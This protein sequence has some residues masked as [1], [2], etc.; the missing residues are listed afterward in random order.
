MSSCSSDDWGA[1][2]APSTP[3]GPPIG[4][5]GPEAAPTGSGELGAV[6][7]G[8]DNSDESDDWGDV[9]AASEPVAAPEEHAPTL[10]D[11][12]DQSPPK[13]RGRGRP[14]KNPVLPKAS[15]G[16]ANLARIPIPAA[17]EAVALAHRPVVPTS[18]LHC[19]AHGSWTFAPSALGRMRR[20]P[21][22]GHPHPLAEGVVQIHASYIAGGP[23]DE[24]GRQVAHSLLSAVQA[25]L[26]STRLHAARAGTNVWNF[27]RR[28][29]TAIAAALICSRAARWELEKSFAAPRPGVDRILYMDY[30]R[31]DETPM[32]VKMAG[33]SSMGGAPAS[34]ASVGPAAAA[35]YAGAIPLVPI[36]RSLV[37]WNPQ[38]GE[39]ATTTA[40][41]GKLLQLDSQ[42]GLLMSI[43]GEHCAVL[44]H[45]LTPLQNIEACSARCLLAAQHCVSSLSPAC[46]GFKQRL[47]AST[48]DKAA[49]NMLCEQMAAQ[50]MDG[51]SFKTIHLGCDIH[52]VSRVHTRV[53]DLAESTIVGVLR[54]AL[55]VQGGAL[56]NKFRQGL[57]AEI[58]SRGGVCIK[59]GVCP[60]AAKEHREYML[61][62]FCARGRNTLAKKTLL[63][64]LPN[65]DWSSRQVELYLPRR[66]S[67]TQGEAEEQVTNGIVTA[68]TGSAFELYPRHRWTGA[69][70]AIDRCGLLEAVHGLGSGA[71]R[72]FLAIVGGSMQPSEA[73]DDL[74]ADPPRLPIAD[75]QADE[76]PPVGISLSGDLDA[77]PPAFR[78]KAHAFSCSC[79]SFFLRHLRFA[80]EI[81]RTECCLDC[82]CVFDA[83]RSVGGGGDCEWAL[84]LCERIVK[85]GGSIMPLADPL[86]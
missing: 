29:Q 61:R 75:G 34:S 25:P 9:A 3:P 57:R 4:E 78:L 26:A 60:P 54:H 2:A 15:T 35:A 28:S 79:P 63:L 1:I 49:S 39:L 21:V 48:T 19:N 81:F 69:D 43:R 16:S 12:L 85:G 41:P 56:L 68:L 8:S 17:C 59:Y 83:M 84:R 58:R 33:G 13:K 66:S 10:M 77:R 37:P 64:L 5:G 42:Y 32:R 27:A 46:G 65:G 80:S 53:F 20:R 51:V 76:G 11:A 73:A 70:L 44:G 72:Q 6:G 36:N 14:R 67:L 45:V 86:S 24:D 18:V 23:E 74:L 71:Y 47:R 40:A 38:I 55:S 82:M 22:P 30:L 52:T 62:L 7:V 31:Y 50:Q